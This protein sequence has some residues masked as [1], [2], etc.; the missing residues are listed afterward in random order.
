MVFCGFALAGSP[1]GA[2]LGSIMDAESGERLE[3]LRLD[4]SV[5]MGDEAMSTPTRQLSRASQPSASPSQASASPS[6]S[7]ALSRA[8]WRG[9]KQY[10]LGG[11]GRCLNSPGDSPKGHIYN[12]YIELG[13]TVEKEKKERQITVDKYEKKYMTWLR[14]A[15]HREGK[16]GNKKRRRKR[17]RSTKLQHIEA[18]EAQQH[19]EVNLSDPSWPNP[20]P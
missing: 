5:A 14:G 11:S 16:E 3:P 7:N 4:F 12:R 13:K 17:S 18:G 20:P 10:F 6:A 15:G 1:I 8:L 19:T 9:L 2:L